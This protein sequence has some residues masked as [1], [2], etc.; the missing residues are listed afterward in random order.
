MEG[1]RPAEEIQAVLQQACE[2]KT[3]NPALIYKIVKQIGQG[4]FGTIFKVM[5]SK[6]MKHY[7]LKYNKPKR[8]SERDEIINECSLIKHLN[9]EQL[10]NCH[11]V[12]E[13]NQRVWVILEL[14]E[15]GALTDI[16]LE[17]SG[18][19]SEDFVRWS[20]YQVAK[21]LAAMHS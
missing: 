16:I 5:H 3:E 19:L 4:S 8:R 6:T 18:K 14:M 17:R 1:F 9:C 20:L 15:G 12:Y 13:F 7:A 10:I 11:E 2:V 21:G